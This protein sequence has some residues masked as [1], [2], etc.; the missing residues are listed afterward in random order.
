MGRPAPN[1]Q[2]LGTL[3]TDILH[4]KFG[5]NDNTWDG[6]WQYESVLQGNQNRW[7]V[8]V[9]VPF[10]TMG[11]PPPATG[12]SWWANFGRVHFYDGKKKRELSVW[13]AKLNISRTPGDG[14]F[15]EIVFE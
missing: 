14:Y 5:W 1:R 8:L 10:K 6:D 7:L 4:P 11:V 3:K 15:G 9:T 13:T 12:T 2:E